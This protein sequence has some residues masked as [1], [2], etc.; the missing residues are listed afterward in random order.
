[1][2]TLI[3]DDGAVLYDSRVI[4]EYLD[5]LRQRPRPHSARGTSALGDVLVLQS[6]ADGISD[7]AVLARYETPVRPEAIRW[8]EWTT[9]QLNKVTCPQLDKLESRAAGSQRTTTSTSAP[10]AF[11]SGAGLP[12]FS[13]RL[14][15]LARHA[16]AGV[17]VV[18][19]VRRAPVDGGDATAGGVM[20][21]VAR[22]PGA[23]R[24]PAL[25]WKT[26]HAADSFNSAWLVR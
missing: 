7:A 12:R 15:R 14:A 19:A 18:R 10:S 22:W 8:N 16:T 1:M 23:D 4:C 13:L 3:T 11:G 5:T 20:R 26:D 21:S 6:L 9:G 2:P 25:P 24:A 17:G